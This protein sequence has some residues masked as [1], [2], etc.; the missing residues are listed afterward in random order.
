LSDRIVTQIREAARDIHLPIAARILDLGCGSGSVAGALTEEVNAPRAFG[1][2]LVQSTR[3]DGRI[4][5]AVADG[6]NLPF[7]DSTFDL[8][9]VMTV[10]SSI[11]SDSDRDRTAREATRVTR[12]GGVV[13]VYDFLIKN[14]LNPFTRGLS[15]KQLARALDGTQVS[16]ERVTLNPVLTRLVFALPVIDPEAICRR[17]ERWSALRHHVLVRAVKAT[18]T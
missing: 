12:T 17:L 10:L 6:R 16:V 4:H 13:L 5:F 3:L 9:L 14:P 1:V 18:S 7:A 11:P 15:L 8:T 2:D